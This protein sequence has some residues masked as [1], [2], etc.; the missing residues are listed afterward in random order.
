MKYSSIV[1]SL[2]ILTGCA[3]ITP[4]VEWVASTE[5]DRFTDQTTCT[6]TTGS[7][8]TQSSVFTYTNH[9]YPFIE[10]VEDELRVG[11][12]SGGKYKVPVG[13]IQLRIDK[14]KAWDISMSETPVNVKPNPHA[15]AQVDVMTEY[16][17]NLPP[18][19]QALVVNS[20]KAAMSSTGKMLS[21]YTATTGDKAKA[22]VKEMLKG[23]VLIYRTLGFSQI[24]NYGG[25]TTGE[26]ILNGSLQTALNKCQ[27]K[28]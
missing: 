7:L 22:I 12:K 18:E 26:F 13:D 10:V 4:K 21:P 5:F 3:S 15:S 2:V 14:N 17:K 9:L 16:A 24:P 6:V 20:Y 19:Q 27:I 28:I 8:Y 1:F 25:G 11:L 23:N